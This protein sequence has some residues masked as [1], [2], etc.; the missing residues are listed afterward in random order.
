M[1]YDNCQML[2]PEGELMCVV[3]SKRMNW[4]VS[5]GLAEVVSEDPPTFMLNF[6]PAGV[7]S[8]PG[9]P[10]MRRNI[11]VVCGC[12]DNLTKHHVVPKCYVK[13]FPRK[14]KDRNSKDILVLC[15]GHHSEYEEKAYSMRQELAV[16]F[17]APVEDREDVDFA[18]AAKS[19]NALSSYGHKIPQ[20]RVDRLNGR[21]DR[22]LKKTGMTRSDLAAY[23]SFKESHAE[24]VV[25]AI[26]PGGI[27]DF[28]DR[29]RRHFVDTMRPR[30]LPDDWKDKEPGPSNTTA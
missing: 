19:L 14:Y 20:E 29:W 17:G 6:K 18:M 11:C 1:I 22:Y 12:S 27:G 16:E 9:G 13:H 25:A 8:V 10:L 4:Y 15:R 28:A 2:S 5:R 23:S 26:G 3:S 30:H 7:G 24:K 21:V